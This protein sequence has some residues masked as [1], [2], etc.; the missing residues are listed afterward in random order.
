MDLQG[1]AH[2]FNNKWT[3]FL[4]ARLNCSVPGQIPFYFNE[5]QS[6]TGFIER[7]EP[8]NRGSAKNEQVSTILKL[9]FFAVAD[10]LEK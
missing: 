4:K 9:F 3:S 7:T 5:I 10:S 8:I 2:K 1:G 6:T